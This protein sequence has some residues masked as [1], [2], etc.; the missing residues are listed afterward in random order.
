MHLRASLVWL[1]YSSNPKENSH[2]HIRAKTSPNVQEYKKETTTWKT[3]NKPATTTVRDGRN[4][5]N[6]QWRWKLPL[7]VPPNVVAQEREKMRATLKCN[8]HRD[9]TT[10]PHLSPAAMEL[11]KNA[12][13]ISK[14][15]KRNGLK[16][17]AA[18]MESI[19][20]LLKRS[21]NR[22]WVYHY[23]RANLFITNKIRIFSINEFFLGFHRGSNIS[24]SASIFQTVKL[25]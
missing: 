20:S 9:H 3:E 19:T 25:S 2:S 18:I 22:A 23:S 5:S 13:K 10:H 6:N 11:Q 15:K 1:D 24:S 12:H 7:D 14:G 8:R 16:T 17:K 21:L 4:K